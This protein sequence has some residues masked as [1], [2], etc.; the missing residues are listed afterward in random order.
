MKM[1]LLIVYMKDSANCKVYYEDKF[2]EISKLS[3]ID[4]N[5]KAWLQ[6]KNTYSK[7]D[8]NYLDNQ[9]VNLPDGQMNGTRMSAE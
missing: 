5:L 9:K 8:S 3:K 4:I 6:W 1:L 7:T 2:Q